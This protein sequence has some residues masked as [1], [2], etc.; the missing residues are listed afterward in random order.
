M[1]RCRLRSG[2]LVALAAHDLALSIRRMDLG[3][4]LICAKDLGRALSR[5]M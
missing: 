2:L 5:S 3:R 1:I 4:A